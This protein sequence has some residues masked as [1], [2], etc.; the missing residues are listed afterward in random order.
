MMNQKF[1]TAIVLGLLIGVIY[2]SLVGY[3]N[4]SITQTILRTLE[5]TVLCY[6]ILFVLDLLALDCENSSIVLLI[7]ILLHIIVRY[8][9]RH[10]QERQMMSFIETNRLRN[11]SIRNRLDEENSKL[12]IQISS[13]ERNI[14]DLE[15]K[16]NGQLSINYFVGLLKRCGANIYNIE[17][18]QRV[19]DIS[20]IG[21]ELE[22]NRERLN[23]LQRARQENIDQIARL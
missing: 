15:N 4:R 1:E 5:A 22:R 11:E 23:Q 9:R 18:N 7:Y 17:L 3:K 14:S 6:I 2:F 13:I 12:D 8:L 21:D 10:F 19:Y 20:K 16:V